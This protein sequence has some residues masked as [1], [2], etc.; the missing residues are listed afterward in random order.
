MYESAFMY[1]RKVAGLPTI[2]WLGIISLISLII[3]TYALFGPFDYGGFASFK[4]VDYLFYALA[5]GIGI[6]I[7]LVAW[8][9]RKR[10]GVQISLAFSE[11]P[12]E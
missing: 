4:L 9:I 2:T 12:P 3:G 11:I 10:Q 6:V 5:Y 8:G 1:K 7:F